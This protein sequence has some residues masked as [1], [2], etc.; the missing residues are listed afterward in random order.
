MTLTAIIFKT[1]E[2]IRIMLLAI[3][4]IS[5]SEK[6]VSEVLLS[7]IKRIQVSKLDYSKDAVVKLTWTYL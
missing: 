2:M 6:P 5:I 7:Q 1:S 4:K 3:E